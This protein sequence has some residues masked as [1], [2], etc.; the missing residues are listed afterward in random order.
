MA[1]VDEAKYLQ[2]AESL[3]GFRSKLRI[4]AD[5]LDIAVRQQILRLLVKEVLVG[6]ATITLRHSIPIPLS[7]PGSN[8]SPGP[9][10]G[11]TAARPTPGYLL[12]SGSRQSYACQLVHEPSV[13][14]LAEHQTGE[15]SMTPIS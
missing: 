14:G 8:G 5:A 9:A 2:L 7:G 1:A 15:S 13:E 6:N 11:V 3:T 10:S 4:R 12:R